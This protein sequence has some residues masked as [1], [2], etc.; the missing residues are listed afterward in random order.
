MLVYADKVKENKTA[1][2]QKVVQ[3]S[4]NLGIDP[5]W[6]MVVMNSESGL[7]HRIKNKLKDPC[8]GLIQFCSPSRQA[9]NVSSEQLI[10]MSNVQQLDY[11]QKYYRLNGTLRFK[12]A[13]D[14]YLYTFYPVAV[15]KNWSDSQTFP[16]NVVAA[17]KG[18]D[19]DKNGVLTVGE[20]RKYVR[21]KQAL[22]GNF[23]GYWEIETA[24]NKEKIKI[25]SMLLG[26]LAMF[27]AFGLWYFYFGGRD[28]LSS[29]LVN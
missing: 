3:I 26:V 27:S 21:Q 6:L 4:Q 12:D 23:A 11:V 2:L 28:K 19:L 1:F 7:N 20:F 9:L 8:V 15:I 18:F 5:N 10:N 13:T 25:G 14:L 24:E 17:N 16:S 22:S 29:F